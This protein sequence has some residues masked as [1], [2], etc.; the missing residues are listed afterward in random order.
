MTSQNDITF[1]RKASGYGAQGL[2]GHLPMEEQNEEAENR[3]W[4]SFYLAV[5]GWWWVDCRD[6]SNRNEPNYWSIRTHEWLV[7]SAKGYGD[8][9]KEASRRKRV[10][11]VHVSSIIP[12]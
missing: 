9:E 7:P 8:R 2:K 10:S 3:P 4:T 12:L 1:K 5:V 6:V 11:E